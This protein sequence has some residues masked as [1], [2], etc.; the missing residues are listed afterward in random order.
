MSKRGNDVR[1]I[2]TYFN[3]IRMDLG[4]FSEFIESIVIDER[5]LKIFQN[6]ESKCIYQTF[7]ISWIRI[8]IEFINSTLPN[9]KYVQLY[10]C[11]DIVN[12]CTNAKRS[13]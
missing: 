11:D 10:D 12:L 9:A 7:N 4:S 2:S 1:S 6:I 5:E 13:M 8:P 3:D